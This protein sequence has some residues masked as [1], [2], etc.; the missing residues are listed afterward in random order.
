MDPEA[1]KKAFE[2]AVNEKL[3][4]EMHKLQAQFNRDMQE[5]TNAADRQPV[6][7]AS[8]APQQPPQVADDRGPS[9]AAIDE[10]RLALREA[11]AASALPVT[12]T[13]QA[14]APAPQPQPE[15]P[16]QLA[17]PPLTQTQAPATPPVVQRRV[18]R[19][20]DVIAFDDLDVRPEPISSPRLIYPPL[21]RRQHA[22]AS[23]ILTVFISET[24]QVLDVKVLRGDARFGFEEEAI[25]ALRAVRFHPATKGGKR[26]RTW[27]PQP[28]L[29]KLQ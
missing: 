24:G 9:A 28:I 6:L 5:K 14:V 11:A 3:Q 27:M 10:R 22:E 8:I 1:Q 16:A 18:V 26:V 23:L 20:G 7:T 19:E 29:F 25:R 17:P 21:A 13:M 15:S 2:E 12:Q 4:A